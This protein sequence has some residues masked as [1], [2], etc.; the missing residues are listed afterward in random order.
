M[1]TIYQDLKYQGYYV[2]VYPLCSYSNIKSLVKWVWLECIIVNLTKSWE[3]SAK[4]L[5]IKF[6][7]LMLNETYMSLFKVSFHPEECR[8]S[9]EGHLWHSKWIS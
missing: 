2:F 5:A 9:H 6:S 4:L 8:W 7:I 3:L 1:S